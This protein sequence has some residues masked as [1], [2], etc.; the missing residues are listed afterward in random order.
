MISCVNA[1]KALL[2]LT[3]RYLLLDVIRI[4]A[5]TADSVNPSDHP[6]DA[7]V[8]LAGAELTVSRRGTSVCLSTL[9]ARTVSVVTLVI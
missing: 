2:A 1:L 8:R 3:A 7:T 5:L 9:P 6:T 4:P